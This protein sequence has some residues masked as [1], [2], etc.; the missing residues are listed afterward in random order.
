MTADVLSVLTAD[1]ISLLEAAGQGWDKYGVDAAVA[2]CEAIPHHRLPWTREQV[3]YYRRVLNLPYRAVVISREVKS[4]LQRRREAQS[5]AGFGHILPDMDDPD[6]HPAILLGPRQLAVVTL[7]RDRGP[8]TRREIIAALEMQAHRWPLTTGTRSTL[9]VLVNAEVLE[10]QARRGLHHYQ[11]A[12]A[13][14]PLAL[15]PEAEIK[16]RT[17]V[18]RRYG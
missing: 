18:E 13:L 5:A 11:G 1:A 12:F 14:S 10:G 17:S 7:L 2:L 8:L 3:R 15:T 4:L 16:R 6:R 9:A